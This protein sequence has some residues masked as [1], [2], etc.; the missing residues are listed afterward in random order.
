VR[1]LLG[2]V[3]KKSTVCG[4]IEAFGHGIDETI[5]GTSMVPLLISWS[6]D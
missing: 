2:F 6:F 1:Q 3:S 4:P 5:G